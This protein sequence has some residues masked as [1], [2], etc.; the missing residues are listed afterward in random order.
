M[1]GSAAGGQRSRCLARKRAPGDGPGGQLLHGLTSEM[2]RNWP[3][4][5]LP[6]SKKN[7]FCSA[8]TT[9]AAFR[10]PSAAPSPACTGAAAELAAAG[11]PAG[12]VGAKEGG[13]SCKG[14]GGQGWAGQAGEGRVCAGGDAV[15]AM[16]H[17]QEGAQ[18]AAAAAGAGLAQGEAPRWGELWETAC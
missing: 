7:F 14:R 10:P 3:R 2:R 17:A 18:V 13:T 8:R 11:G 15:G 9:R 5:L 12:E 16:M 6:R 4:A 1:Q